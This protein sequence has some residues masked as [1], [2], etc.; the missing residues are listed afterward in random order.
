MILAYAG[1]MSTESV[2]PESAESLQAIVMRRLVYRL[3]YA[4][5]SKL[6]YQLRAG[7]MRW[8]LK[9]ASAGAGIASS[10]V[11]LGLLATSEFM[12]GWQI[13]SGA[14]AV[15]SILALTLGWEAQAV[16]F[17]KAA[18]GH[19]MVQERIELLLGELRITE[20][21]DRHV[22]REAE[23][24]AFWQML[25]PLDEQPRDPTRERAWS[26]M[27]QGLPMEGIWDRV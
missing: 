15:A 14:S 2:V 6:Y 25:S 3:Q 9:A 23:I 22:A 5:Y 16:Q 4:T 21:D 1:G 12:A 26:M 20:I 10:A 27:E 11:L 17:E 8:R 24:I 13:I 18:M 7:Q 19:A